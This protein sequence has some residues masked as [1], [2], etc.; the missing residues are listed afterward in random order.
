MN[1]YRRLGVHKWASIREIKRA[2]RELA[3]IHHP[4]KGGDPETFLPIKEAYEALTDPL[5]RVRQDAQDNDAWLQAVRKASLEKDELR[6]WQEVQHEKFLDLCIDYM[7]DRTSTTNNHRKRKR[8]SS[9]YRA[10]KRRRVSLRGRTRSRAW[11]QR[12]FFGAP[13]TV[14]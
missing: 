5:S 13:V 1:H 6:Q 4:D 8:R 7:A 2:Y 12:L 9:A 11:N 14:G 10:A 3:R